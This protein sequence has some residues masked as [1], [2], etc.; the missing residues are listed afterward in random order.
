MPLLNHS[1]NSWSEA[2]FDSWWNRP[3]AT[4]VS[5]VCFK[6]IVA[7]GANRIS[8]HRKQDSPFYVFFEVGLIKKIMFLFAPQ[9]EDLKAAVRPHLGFSWRENDGAKWAGRAG[10]PFKI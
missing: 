6:L 1:P 10:L 8:F 5:H 2:R 4:S 9:N 3:I 7:G